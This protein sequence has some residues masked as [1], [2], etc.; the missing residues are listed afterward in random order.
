MQQNECFSLSYTSHTLGCELK[1]P[2]GHLR[3]DPLSEQV[4][5]KPKPSALASM[6]TRR[7]HA[8]EPTGEVR[9]RKLR[10]VSWLEKGHIRKCLWKYFFGHVMCTAFVTRGLRGEGMCERKVRN[11]AEGIAVPTSLR[12]STF[13]RQRPCC[14]SSD[15]Q[16]L[17]HN[18]AHGGHPLKK[19]K[20]KMTRE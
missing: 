19:G 2:W 10:L 5:G 8:Q 3:G 6:V 12:K 4:A 9:R 20:C 11:R 7:S 16:D 14:L 17:L 15:S 1:S 18:L 13:Q